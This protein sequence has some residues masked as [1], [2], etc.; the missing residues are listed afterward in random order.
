MTV[1]VSV[2][3]KALNEEDSIARSIRSALQAVQ[4]FGGEVILADSAS[5]DRT[6]EIASQFPI[7]IVQLA[8]PAERR[9]GIG[10][11]LG[12]QHAA[13]EYVYILD[14]DMELEPDFMKAAVELMERS[15]EIGGVA[16]LVEQLQSEASFQF[17]GLHRRRA[18]ARP[19]EVAWLDM[20][21]LYRRRALEQ[22][23]YFSNRNLH[24]FEEMELGLRLTSAGWKLRRLPI[25]SV[26]HEGYDLDTL[27]LLRRRWRTRYL[28]GAGE[29]LRA[30]WREPYF[31]RAVATQK[32]LLLAL[33]AVRAVRIGSLKD[34][35]LGQL[36]WQVPALALVRGLLAPMV[37][38]RRPIDDRVMQREPDAR[39][40]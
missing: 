2:I 21:G 20:G 39:A 15:P 7:T 26:R 10:P 24:A 4:P 28:L 14:G 12:Y 11:Q 5:T 33:I 19:G 22:A 8:N 32:F 31:M 17:R 6:V 37:D 9:C 23:G 35:L 29:V 40:G 1:R 16:G 3:I 27:S 36:V 18:E 34:A 13:G 25:R 38:P 30:S